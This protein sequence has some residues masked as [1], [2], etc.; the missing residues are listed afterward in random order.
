M[1]KYCSY[2]TVEETKSERD[3]DTRAILSEESI[4]QLIS[5]QPFKSQCLSATS[6][7]KD[8]IPRRMSAMRD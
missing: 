1:N 2:F 7:I 3:K 6:Y 5:D 4:S 8:V